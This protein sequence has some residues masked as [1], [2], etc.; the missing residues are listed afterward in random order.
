MGEI[1]KKLQDI[2]VRGLQA[3]DDAGAAAGKPTSF[4]RQQQ[5]AD[6]H[7]G[8]LAEIWQRGFTQGLE[9]GTF[10]RIADR[11]FEKGAAPGFIGKVM[12]TIKPTKYQPSFIDISKLWRV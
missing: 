10:H 6:E 2:Q 8:N 5:S 1:L 9:D 3:I 12:S 11:L 7:L 4:A